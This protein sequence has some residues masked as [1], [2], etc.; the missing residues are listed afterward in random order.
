MSEVDKV[1]LHQTAHP[2]NPEDSS[3]RTL[4]HENLKS[5][6]LFVV[7]STAIRGQCQSSTR[8]FRPPLT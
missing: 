7:S 4:R 5:Y 8:P 3:L 1:I 6:S 2:Y